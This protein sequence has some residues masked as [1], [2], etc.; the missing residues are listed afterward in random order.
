MFRISSFIAE[1][2]SPTPARPR[3][4]LPGPVVIWNLIRR[5]NLLCA[6]CYSLSADTDFRGE[7]STDEALAVIDDLAAMRVPALILSGGEPLLRAD[8]FTLARY[9]KEKGLYTA[10]STNG[11]LID[12]AMAE[13]IAATDFDYVGISLDGLGETHDRF[14]RKEGAFAAS[15]RALL[16]LRDLG[17]KVGVRYT[18]TE[19]NAHDFLPLLDWVAEAEIPRFY[20]SHLNYAGRG[21]KNRGC[22]AVAQTTR[23]AMTTLFERAL[24]DHQA[25]I[26]REYTT[27]NHDADGPFFL[28]W[29]QERFPDRAEQIAAKLRQWGG[30]ASGENIANIDNL[31][32]VHPDTMWWHVTLG[33][34]RERPFSAIWRDESSPLL[35]ALRQYPRAVGGRCASCR[36]LPLC[37]GSSRVRAESASGDLW[38]EDPACYLTDE[39]IGATVAEAVSA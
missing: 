26:V 3:R 14:R 1:L 32:N 4:R 23:W 36:F 31:G 29:V 33:N 7:L 22:D 27:G 19:E 28:L 15:Q 17:V 11:T 30:N 8:L 16:Q 20:F 38:G 12:E 5:C 10:L 18:M 24:A 35:K 6:H 2:F 34:V 25:G 37:N 21:K 39:E 13:R 9:A